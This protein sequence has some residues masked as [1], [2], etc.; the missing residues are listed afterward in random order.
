MTALSVLQVTGTVITP[1]C[2]QD[3]IFVSQENSEELGQ[4]EEIEEES[5]YR[6]VSGLEQVIVTGLEQVSEWFRTVSDWSRT[7]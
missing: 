6:L 4:H 1:P 5:G 2:A 3:F 7:V